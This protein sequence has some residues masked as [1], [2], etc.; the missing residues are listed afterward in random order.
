MSAN[1]ASFLLL[2]LLGL[3]SLASPAHSAIT[4]GDLVFDGK[5]DAVSFLAG[6]RLIAS[7]VGQVAVRFSRKPGTED[8][9]TL[10]VVGGR[11][12]NFT[13]SYSPGATALSF[14]PLGGRAMLIGDGDIAKSPDHLLQLLLVDGGWTVIL[15]GM[16][17]AILNT[18]GFATDPTE[19]LTME[20]GGA[21]FIG[22]V[23]VM[24]TSPDG[25]PYANS[26]AGGKLVLRGLPQP[27]VYIEQDTGSTNVAPETLP[28]I[29][30]EYHGVFKKQTFYAVVP[31]SDG[32]AIAVDWGGILELVPDP[33]DPRLY[34]PKSGANRWL[35]SVAFDPLTTNNISPQFTPTGNHANGTRPFLTNGKK[36]IRLPER[37][38][39]EGEQQ[40]GSIWSS[41]AMPANFLHS[42]RSCFNTVKMNLDNLQ[43]NGCGANA[44]FALPPS[45]LGNY[46]NLANK[47]IL[48]F[49]WKWYS[50]VT[51]STT[52]F[53][54][55]MS[56]SQ[57]ATSA[58]TG[59][60]ASGFNILGYAQ[61]RNEKVETEYR[62]VA[63]SQKIETV[64]NYFARQHSIVLDPAMVRLDPC[65]IRRVLR[66]A[67]GIKAAQLG[68][69]PAALTDAQLPKGPDY[70]EPGK[71][72]QACNERLNEPYPVAK[73]L[74][75]YGT[76]Y[77]NAIT[78]GA[79]G[80]RTLRVSND[81]VSNMISSRYDLSLTS[82]IELASN[83]GLATSDTGGGLPSLSSHVTISG[84]ASN[85]S[86]NTTTNSS[87][88]SQSFKIEMDQGHC[89]GGVSCHDGV[90]DPGNEPI[91]IYLDLVR[92][93]QLLAPP[94]FA[95]MTVI[96]DLR[97]ALA[98]EVDK[99]IA[100]SQAPSTPPLRIVDVELL[101]KTCTYAPAT[102]SSPGVFLDQW[103][104]LPELCY[105]ADGLTVA[106]TSTDGKST[107][108]IPLREIDANSASNTLNEA[109][110]LSNMEACL[111]KAAPNCRRRT[112]RMIVHTRYDQ[113]GHA[114]AGQYV[115]LQLFKDHD[116]AKTTAAQCGATHCEPQL[117][118]L[119]TAIG[120]W[121]RD[122]PPR[123]RSFDFLGKRCNADYK[124]QT[125]FTD[126]TAVTTASF[127]FPET[128]AAPTRL[129]G[130][131]AV[132]PPSDINQV[133]TMLKGVSATLP[134]TTDPIVHIALAFKVTEETISLALGYNPVPPLQIQPE[135][136]SLDSLQPSNAFLWQASDGVSNA[137]MFRRCETVFGAGNCE[138]RLAIVY[139]RP[140]AQRR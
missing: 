41:Q 111:D 98:Q 4:P 121:L 2:L 116:T 8:E 53:S 80:I 7:G 129:S 21:G 33:A 83:V 45:E 79:R 67:A 137:G 43:E 48:P 93:D 36:Y 16:Q 115:A 56:S 37:P 139:A 29:P 128:D 1:R 28:G 15:D 123:D 140:A 71:S 52:L 60:S 11:K 88:T 134:Q 57:D 101:S 6:Q 109:P 58:H 103:E 104:W 89:Y 99:A 78:Y 39:G 64:A 59:T 22:T 117:V 3:L 119:Y 61:S 81:E 100:P 110:L 106:A 62:T 19:P 40:I 32:V 92:L 65:F 135:N 9:A 96:R 131:F 97:K 82:G 84:G 74:T 44:L 91:P 107:T 38:R 55:I 47:D 31:T 124:R 112:Y 27:G 17:T 5:D 77:A 66:A 85:S 50:D 23:S 136:L 102:Q 14:K 24:V 73:L 35:G 54:T 72:Y 26:A 132:F 127:G 138:Q 34:S 18:P 90:T 68:I 113:P 12:T 10:L 25:L 130:D 95:D 94:F 75:D 49:G 30:L 105:R 108:I 133:L 42:V 46:T 86:G 126:P 70:F 120:Q 118:W 51:S 76:H 114:A 63:N 20:I 122:C 125:L 87:T 69:A 13:I